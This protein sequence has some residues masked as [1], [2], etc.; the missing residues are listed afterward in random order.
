MSIVF[1]R[2][3]AEAHAFLDANPDITS[4]HVIWTDICGVARGKILRRDELV[5]AWKDGRFMPI[6]ALVLDITGQDVPETGLVFDEGD[7]DMLLWPVHGSL[8]RIPWMEEPTAQ[9]LASVHDLDGTPHYA[10]PRN[11]LEAIVKRFQTELNMTPVG[12]VELEFFLMDRA[13]AIAG[14]PRAPK[15]LIN[16][17]RPQHFQA[18]YLQDLDDFAPFFKDL[19]AYCDAQGL[20]AKTLISEYAPGQ[21]EIVLR[22]RSDVLK[23]CDE[24]IML[25]RVIKATAEKHGM[26]ATFMAKPYAQWT[27][28]GMHIHVSLG[29]VQGNNLFAAE[30]PMQNELLLHAI[31]GLKAAMAESMLIFAPNA[32]SYRRFRRNSYAPVSA[33]WG[34][35]N[36]TVSL[37]IPAGAANACHIEHRPSGADANPYLVMAAILAGMHYGITEKADPG[38]PVVGNGYEK[39]AKYIPGNWFDAIDAFWR[40]SILKE[41]FGKP[42]VDT[43]CTIK[44]VEADRFYAEPTLRD[45]EWYLRVV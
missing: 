25:K 19:Y 20:P 14:E 40:A 39:R 9:Y 42:F 18:Y 41:Y 32:N 17:H 8:V 44:E 30:D 12:A 34:I 23:A 3:E 2:R 33:S 4:I 7:R 10:D 24:G 27:G 45:F 43:Y 6:S 13:S 29:D 31:G 5:P 37:R 11:A 38:N 36:R 26:A 35:N 15:S 28:S 21:M 22:H 1:P 16:E